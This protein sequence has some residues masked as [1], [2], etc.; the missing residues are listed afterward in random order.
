LQPSPNPALLKSQADTQ[1]VE[2]QWPIDAHLDGTAGNLPATH[3]GPG[4]QPVCNR[5]TTPRF[6][7]PTSQPVHPGSSPL[8]TTF[9]ELEPGTG[10]RF[11]DTH[12]QTDK[13]LHIRQLLSPQQAVADQKALFIGVIPSN[14]SNHVTVQVG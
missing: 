6:Q 8:S 10:T 5:E 3:F 2:A 7:T 9:A 1:Q 12:N 4:L 13:I 11:T 14:P